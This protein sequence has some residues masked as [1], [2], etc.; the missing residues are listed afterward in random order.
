[1]RIFV[2]VAVVVLGALTALSARDVEE[3]DLRMAMGY[4]QRGLSA[5]QKGNVARARE[6]FDRALAKVA[7]LPDAHTGLGHL[8]MRERRFEDAL[9]E[10]RLAEAGWRD[11]T[12]IRVRMETER[13]ARSR[14]EIQRLRALQL[15]LAQAATR[16]QSGASGTTVSQPRTARASANGDRGEDPVARGH[17]RA[18]GGKREGSARR[19][20]LLQGNALF[21][22]K[23]TEEAIAAWGEAAAQEMRKS[24]RSRTIS[25]SLTGKPAGST[26][27]G[28]R[29]TSRGLGIQG[30][31]ELPRGSREGRDR[32]AVTSSVTADMISSGSSNWT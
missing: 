5:L 7:G 22:L 27:H 25:R 15:E 10:Y 30:Q 11:M 13:Y 14:D 29:P 1:M 8:A 6:D 4:A 28:P 2:G 24:D 3:R 16:S 32:A 23:R 9:R 17:E 26:M 31:S 18:N 20:V 21:D 19:R 12:S